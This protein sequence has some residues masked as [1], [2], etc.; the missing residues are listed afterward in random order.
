[1]IRP[2]SVRSVALAA[3]AILSVSL[4]ACGGGGGGDDGAW[5]VQYTSFDD[6]AGTLDVGTGKTTQFTMNWQATLTG[7]NTGYYARAYLV[8][9]GSGAS[10][11]TDENMLVSSNCLAGFGCTS[12]VT[13]T[14]SDTAGSTADTRHIDCGQ[15]VGHNRAKDIA[16]GSYS[17]VGQVC[18]VDTAI[19]TICKAQPAQPIMLR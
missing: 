9:T 2:V 3:L 12:A 13:Q 5:G 6:G 15:T 1:M 10:A 19:N 17:M 11:L 7:G 16:P 14:C 18:W 4:S 8:P